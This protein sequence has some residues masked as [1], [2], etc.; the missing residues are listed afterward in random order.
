MMYVQRKKA[1]IFQINNLSTAAFIMLDDNLN[2]DKFKTSFGDLE[3]SNS[4]K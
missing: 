2:I 4:T 1:F 3:T